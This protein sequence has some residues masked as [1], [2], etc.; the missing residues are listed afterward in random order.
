MSACS[1]VCVTQLHNC[2]PFLL[3]SWTHTCRAKE[4]LCNYFTR[5]MH[6][7]RVKIHADIEL[8]LKLT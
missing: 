2:N 5:Q 4:H 8:Q 7:L 6:T 1:K 3:L